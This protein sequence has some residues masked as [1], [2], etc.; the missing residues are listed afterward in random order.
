MNEMKIG[1]IGAGNMA[2]AL[3]SGLVNQGFQPGL[4]AADPSVETRNTVSAHYAIKT[5]A[6]NSDAVLDKDVIILAVKPQIMETVL[7]SIKPDIKNWQLVISVAAGITCEQIHTIL[8]A[9]QP[10]VRA[11]PNTPALIGA[12]ITG[13]FANHHV[14]ESQRQLAMRIMATTGEAIWIEGENQMNAVTAVSGSGPAYFLL[15]IEALAKAGE[16]VGLNQET[17]ARLALVTAAGAGQLALK[18][19]VSPAELRQRVTSPG[20]TTAA[21]LNVLQQEGFNDVVLKAV[22]AAEQR[23]NELADNR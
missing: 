7:T 19:D 12:G 16:N 15:L 14:S 20:G 3:I 13:M 22:I 2:Q 17:A 21:A 1:I 18:S 11:M 10:I 23:G 8:P 5:S 6:E 4:T 9:Q